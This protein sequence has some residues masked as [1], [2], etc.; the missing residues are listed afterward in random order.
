MS[1]VSFHVKRGAYVPPAGLPRGRS[2]SATRSSL[3]ASYSFTPSSHAHANTPRE[4]HAIA[5]VAP[6]SRPPAALSVTVLCPKQRAHAHVH[7][8]AIVAVRD[9][10]SAASARAVVDA[11]APR[12]SRRARASSASPR[13]RPPA[14]A[15]RPRVRSRPF[16]RLSAAR[17]PRSR[18]ERRR[19]ARARSRRPS[20]T[21]SP[22]AAFASSRS[23]VAASRALATST[24]PSS[25][26]MTQRSFRATTSVT[27]ASFALVDADCCASDGL[28]LA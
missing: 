12:T 15:P 5:R 25:Y 18:L 16:H 19:R 26:A 27:D 10:A 4:L 17:A 23:P 1:D 21:P 3:P 7:P 9:A 14:R 2:T 20:P 11:R 8:T 13:T 28:A 6:R 24:H 22:R